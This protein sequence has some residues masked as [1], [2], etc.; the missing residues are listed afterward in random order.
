MKAICLSSLSGW[1]DLLFNG[2][3]LDVLWALL[4]LTSKIYEARWHYS[5]YS[6]VL[7]D[8]LRQQG[9]VG[10]RPSAQWVKPSASCNTDHISSELE[11]HDESVTGSVTHRWGERGSCQS[12]AEQ[13]DLISISVTVRKRKHLSCAFCFLIDNWD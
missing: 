13:F 9:I 1:G 4:F 7:F 12:T 2:S 3:L 5:F 11:C 10:N 6:V 8:Y